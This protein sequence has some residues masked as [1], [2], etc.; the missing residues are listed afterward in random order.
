MLTTKTMK[1]HGKYVKC[2]KKEVAKW[3]KKNLAV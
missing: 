2:L 1:E 3:Q